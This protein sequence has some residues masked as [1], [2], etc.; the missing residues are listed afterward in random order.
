MSRSILASGLAAVA[1][2]AMAFH[3][4]FAQAQS[5]EQRMTRR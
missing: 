1:L 4:L 2:V 3:V 5:G